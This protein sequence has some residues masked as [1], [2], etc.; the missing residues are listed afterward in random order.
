M[1]EEEPL[2]W[3]RMH[4]QGWGIMSKDGG[5]TMAPLTKGTSTTP[6]PLGAYPLDGSVWLRPRTRQDVHR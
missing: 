1:G 3:S 4:A 2:P 5:L 6:D